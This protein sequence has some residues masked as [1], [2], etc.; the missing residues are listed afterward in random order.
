MPIWNVD[1]DD[2]NLNPNPNPN[3]NLDNDA[4]AGN[5]MIIMIINAPK[6]TKM[7]TASYTCYN[8]CNGPIM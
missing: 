4:K 2:L 7:Y 6:G 1:P 3:P 8:L 5:T